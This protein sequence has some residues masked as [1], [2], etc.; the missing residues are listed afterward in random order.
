[1]PRHFPFSAAVYSFWMK[2]LVFLKLTAIDNDKY[3]TFPS[4]VSVA[5]SAVLIPINGLSLAATVARCGY[6]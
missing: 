3:R 6:G 2:I 5:S 4:P 1:M